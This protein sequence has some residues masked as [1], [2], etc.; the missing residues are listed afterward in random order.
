MAATFLAEQLRSAVTA[1]VEGG[2][3]ADIAE[4]QQ[5]FARAAARLD[6]AFRAVDERRRFA[7]CQSVDSVRRWNTEMAEQLEAQGLLLERHR[8]RLERWSRECDV[9]RQLA[10][11]SC[12]GAP[13]VG[14]EMSDAAAAAPAAASGEQSSAGSIP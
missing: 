2:A 4:V 6:A 8:E 13:G 9:C 3:D 10:L 5:S 11:R 12:P 14:V 1:S 7:E